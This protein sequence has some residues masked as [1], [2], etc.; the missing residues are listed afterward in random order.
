MC[1]MP[2][3]PWTVWLLIVTELVVHEPGAVVRGHAGRC[4]LL[5]AA[6]DLTAP[7]EVV[8]TEAE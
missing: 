8:V 2:Y 4:H 7:R 5:L 6:Y 1:D 3:G